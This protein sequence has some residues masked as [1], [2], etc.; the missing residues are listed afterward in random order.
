MRE[1]VFLSG[2]LHCLYLE[3]RSFLPFPPSNFT[4]CENRSLVTSSSTVFLPFLSLHLIF[5]H[6]GLIHTARPDLFFL[7]YP[8]CIQIY[9]RKSGQQKTKWKEIFANCI[10]TTIEDGLKCDSR[11]STVASQIGHWPLKSDFKMSFAWHDTLHA[12]KPIKS[13]VMEWAGSMLLLAEC[14]QIV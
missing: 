1:Q 11:I 12:V 4:F 3:K 13:R 6:L 9:S 7:T 14:F 10:K 2:Y 8:D 5:Y